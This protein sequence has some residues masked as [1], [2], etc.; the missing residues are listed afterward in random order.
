LR[1]TKAATLEE[2]IFGVASFYC[3]SVRSRRVALPL[4]VEDGE[5]RKLK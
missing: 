5:P 3:E 1:R 4:C 2:L